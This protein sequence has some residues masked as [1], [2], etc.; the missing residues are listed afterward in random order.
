[1][2]TEKLRVA[3]RYNKPAEY[4]DPVNISFATEYDFLE[5][6]Y[7]TLVEYSPG[8]ELVGA[9]AESFEW[10]GTEARFKIRQGLRTIDGKHID[11]NDV[12]MSFKRLFILGGNTH[13]DLKEI[14]CPNIK[15]K[16]FSDKCPEMQVRDGGQTFVF[17][18]KEKKV[19][20][21]PMLAAIDFAIIPRDSVDKY[22]FKIKGYRN[23]S[24]PYFVSK[25]SP[26]GQIELAPNP[27]HFHYSP[28]IP[29]KVV[30]V[31]SDNHNSLD[32][33]SLFSENKADFITTTDSIP[34]DI[35]ISFANKH[36]KDAELH[37]THA[38]DTFMLIFTK[39]GL[40]RFSENERF[41]I[42]REFK[43]IFQEDYLNKPGYEATDQLFP[44]FGGGGLS[45]E[46]LF[47]IK[48][49]MST[50]ES[51]DVKKKVI[52]VWNMNFTNNFEATEA[53]YKKVFSA[54]KF[55]KTGKIPGRVDYAAE[56]LSEP[57]FYLARSDMGFQEDINLLSY[58]FGMDFFYLPKGGQKPWLR[59]YVSTQD[60]QERLRLLRE[61]HFQT[62][63]HATVI[64]LAK[65]PY[66]AL[67]RKPWTFHMS[68]FHANDPVWRISQE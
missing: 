30:F 4:Y 64:P 23:T 16:S 18:L 38:I 67:V 40:H 9:V 8:G 33:L 57:D 41:T 29:Q 65:T 7:S 58:Y 6:I 66:T 15:L 59:K 24:G 27:V 2:E 51:S 13:G 47:T 68:K 26:S 35:M 20:L 28:K 55:K 60:K 10:A 11:A 31:P 63:L 46:Q 32:S 54:I 12:E 21:F 50:I 44:A 56:K 17:K 62:L 61:L 36:K 49:K 42:G 37:S 19:F 5:N 48:S 25:D 14:V 45:Q 1:M 43:R 39:K 52:T 34:P 3:F 53:D 22:T